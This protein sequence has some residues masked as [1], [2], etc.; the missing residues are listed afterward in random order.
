MIHRPS[1]IARSDVWFGSWCS[2]AL[3]VN[4][5]ANTAIGFSFNNIGVMVLLWEKNGHSA[6]TWA[7]SFFDASVFVGAIIGMPIFGHLADRLGRV[8][9]LRLSLLISAVGALL[10]GVADYGTSTNIVGFL[11][12]WRFF[13]GVGLGGIYPS[14]AALSYEVAID[15]AV[16]ACPD[17][18]PRAAPTGET[19]RLAAESMTCFVNVGQSIGCVLVYL[20]ALLLYVNYI[21]FMLQVSQEREREGEREPKPIPKCHFGA[22]CAVEP[23]CSQWT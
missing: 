6:S 2:A 19:G 18:S 5:L 4:C 17:S 21:N 13:M 1:L 16:A 12:T 23:R 9:A 8:M 7:E 3:V 22:T 20:T 10:S 15:A 11:C 14:S